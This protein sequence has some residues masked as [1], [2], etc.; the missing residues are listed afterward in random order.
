MNVY[1]LITYASQKVLQYPSLKNDINDFLHLAIVEIE[2]GSALEH[3]F[4]LMKDS[5]EELIEERKLTTKS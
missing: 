2:Q 5:I 4:D 1:E 3:E